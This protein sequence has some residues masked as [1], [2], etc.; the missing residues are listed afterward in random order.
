M[1]LTNV[2]LHTLYKRNPTMQEFV[3]RRV[4]RHYE[5]RNLEE[6]WGGQNVVAEVT[7]VV[8][9][10]YSH[11]EDTNRN[12]ETQAGTARAVLPR[13]AATSPWISSHSTKKLLLSKDTSP[14]STFIHRMSRTVHKPDDRK[15]YQIEFSS[16]CRF[17]L[18]FIHYFIYFMHCNF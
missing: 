5:V 2:E 10:C 4:E 12:V 14:D 9:F 16:R 8:F 13:Q 1:P 18:V 3:R 11:Y 6:R 15:I 7:L 17:C